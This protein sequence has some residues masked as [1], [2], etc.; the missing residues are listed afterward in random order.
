VTKVLDEDKAAGRIPDWAWAGVVWMQGEGD[1][2]G[3]MAPAGVYRE[4]LGRLA[5][6]V[7]AQTMVADLPMIVGRISAQLSPAVVRDTGMLRVSQSKSSDGKGIADDADFLDDGRRRG[8]IWYAAKLAQVR[9]DQVAFAT[10]DPCAAWVDIDDL[11]LRDFWH[12]TAGGYAEM[13]RRFARAYRAL[14][15]PRTGAPAIPSQK[16]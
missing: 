8:P 15:A 11:P 6:W 5:A 16:P 7:R 10:A 13:G 4:K 12:Y 1:A 9:A 2:N 3:T 14:T